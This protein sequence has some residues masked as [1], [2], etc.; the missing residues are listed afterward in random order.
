MP[1]TRAL[2]P[3]LTLAEKWGGLPLR[4]LG[5]HPPDRG[6][7]GQREACP[8]LR[9]LGSHRPDRSRREA[10]PLLGLL[11]TH[12]ARVEA[13]RPRLPPVQEKLPQQSTLIAMYRSKHK[14]MFINHRRSIE[15][16]RQT[17]TS[18]PHDRGR[19]HDRR[20]HGCFTS[21]VPGRGETRVCVFSE[22]RSAPKAVSE[23]NRD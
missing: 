3:F 19:V 10:G 14:H 1:H 23:Q 17:Q 8:I 4:L 6:Q 12:E 16:C 18:H 5:A 7:R 22:D 2:C 21:A 20:R 13:V 11:A 9:L 15:I